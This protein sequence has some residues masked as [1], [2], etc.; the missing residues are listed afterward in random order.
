MTILP[1]NN[2]VLNSVTYVLYSEDV[3]YCILIDCGEYETLK[4]VLDRINKK[5]KA[6]LL[7]HGHSFN[8]VNLVKNFFL[9][10]YSKKRHV[11]LK[12]ILFSARKFM[13]QSSRNYIKILRM[14][15]CKIICDKK[16]LLCNLLLL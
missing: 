10:I 7:T 1:V 3:D 9:M 8:Y 5:V 12:E 14:T 2:S 16:E 11:L 15:F 13:T 6:V 4:P